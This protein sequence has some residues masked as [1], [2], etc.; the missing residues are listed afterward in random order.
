MAM[1]MQGQQFNCQGLVFEAITIVIAIVV[2]VAVI[3]IIVVI[4]TVIVRPIHQQLNKQS[5]VK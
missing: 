4:A 1:Q 5:R 2:V 3:A